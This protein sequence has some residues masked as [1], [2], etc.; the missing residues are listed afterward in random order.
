MNPGP[1]RDQYGILH[2]TDPKYDEIKRLF[3]DR[4]GHERLPSSANE[5]IA[6]YIYHR[7]SK[8]LSEAALKELL[9]RLQWILQN[10]KSTEVW[11]RTLKLYAQYSVDMPDGHLEK[12][13]AYAIRNSS[14][15]LTLD[16]DTNFKAL[17]RNSELAPKLIT[18]LLATIKVGGR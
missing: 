13:I 6:A 12:S 9:F 1:R 5:I 11:T 10:E 2:A 15:I 8:L 4:D 3:T 14:I 18:V 17:M 7:S 16:E